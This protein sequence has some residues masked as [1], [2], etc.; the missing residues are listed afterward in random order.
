MK[1]ESSTTLPCAMQGGTRQR[2]KF[3]VC[4]LRDT[5]QRIS[6]F[7]VVIFLFFA[8]CFKKLFKCTWIILRQMDSTMYIR[9]PYKYFTIISCG[10]F[11][12]S[13]FHY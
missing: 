13:N 12:N 2:D 11:S 5:R 8:T 3:V 6:L 1:K 7:H 4:C 9:C 10:Y